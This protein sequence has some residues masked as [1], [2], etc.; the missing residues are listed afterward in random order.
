[1]PR[2]FFAPPQGKLPPPSPALPPSSAGPCPLPPGWVALPRS[3][4]LRPGR[5]RTALVTAA[6][7]MLQAV[8]PDAPLVPGWAPT[9][10]QAQ[11][12]G[13]GQQEPPELPREFRGAWIATVGNIDWPSHH[14]VP[15]ERQ[16]EQLRAILDRAAAMHLNAVIFQVRPAA[17]A[18]YRSDIEPWSPYLTGTMGKDPG[19]DPLQFAIE[20]AHARGLELHA[21]FNPYRARASGWVQAS[22]D[23]IMRTHPEHIRNVGNLRWMDPGEPWVQERT[24]AVI[25]DVVRRYDID[26]VHIDD[27]FYP[28]P[29]QGSRPGFPDDATWQRY[30]TGGGTLERDDWRRNNVNELVR[31]IN[32]TVKE[33]KPW[34]RFGIS[35]FGIWRPRQP[36]AVA[37]G[38]D[39]Y[40]DIFADSRHWL[41][42]GWCDYLAPQLYWRERDS[43][44][45]FGALMEWWQQ[46]NT[47][48]RHLWPGIAVERVGRDRQADE[49]VIQVGLARQHGLPSASGHIMWNISALTTN[50]HRVSD[51]LERHAYRGPT[52]VPATPWLDPTPSRLA[53]HIRTGSAPSLSLATDDSGRPQ[54]AWTWNQPGTEPAAGN[55]DATRW[56]LVQVHDGEQWHV[57]ARLPAGSNRYT[58]PADHN[59]RVCAIRPIDRLGRLGPFAMA[60]LR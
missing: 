57:A 24:L 27:Y 37:A 35:P 59:W 14:S 44:Q 48:Q 33:E 9:A 52:L 40:A 45:P 26:A 31:R 6:L 30:R 41:Q 42:Q 8:V 32:E 16:R 15:A 3:P 38:L 56:W 46:Q 60:R 50:K 7:A 47:M 53:A 17:D 12:R 43:Q 10:A 54:L 11:L 22:A 55:A 5:R 58:L 23:H 49:I 34:V 20:E 2:N 4:R 18:L 19:Y 36:P 29:P 13:Q 1:M 39:S 51:W 21:W 28:Y 25:R